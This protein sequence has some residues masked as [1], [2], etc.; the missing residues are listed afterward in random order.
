MKKERLPHALQDIDQQVMDDPVAEIR[1][2]DFSKLRLLHDET[3]RTGGMVGP[4]VQLL[5]GRCSP[6][7]SNQGRCGS[8][9]VPP[10]EIRAFFDTAAQVGRL[11]R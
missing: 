4:P 9:V 7:T 11:L 2:E 1:R 5:A 3:D 10:A 6:A 8:S